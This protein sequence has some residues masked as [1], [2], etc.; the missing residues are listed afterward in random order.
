MENQDGT[1]PVIGGTPQVLEAQQPTLRRKRVR[2]ICR[3]PRC[4]NTT[5]L[6]SNVPERRLRRN[7]RRTARN[8]NPR[9]KWTTTEAIPLLHERGL[10]HPRVIEV[11]ADSARIASRD[12][13]LPFNAHL[14]LRR[15]AK[16]ASKNKTAHR[17]LTP[18]PDVWEPGQRTR[19]HEQWAIWDYSMSWRMQADGTIG[20]LKIQ[21]FRRMGMVDR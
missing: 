17:T 20:T 9:S 7:R 4:A 13:K 3:N 14:F 8:L 12:L 2:R 11:C 6:R 10:R 16:H 18:A 19:L 15:I 21:E 5:R 1:P